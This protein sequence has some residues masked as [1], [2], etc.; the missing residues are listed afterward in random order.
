MLSLTMILNSCD[1]RQECPDSGIMTCHGACMCGCNCMHDGSK[2]GNVPDSTVFH[3][4]QEHD[5]D[6]NESVAAVIP[7]SSNTQQAI[8]SHAACTD[9]P[10]FIL[11]ADTPAVPEDTLYDLSISD[12]MEYAN[13]V[14]DTTENSLVSTDSVSF[15]SHQEQSGGIPPVAKKTQVAFHTNMLYDSFFIP[16]FGLDIDLGK[17]WTAGIDWHYAWWSNGLFNWRQTY[18]G[19]I[20]VDRHLSKGTDNPFDGHRLGLYGQLLTYDFELGFDGQI[21]ARPNYA[22]GLEYGY[23]LPLGSS[24]HLDL[25]IGLG[26]L[27]GEYMK[28]IPMWNEYPEEWHYVWQST[29]KTSYFGVTKAEINLVWHIQQKEDRK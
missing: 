14:S 6:C 27:W 20:H 21:A 12:G 23:S 9:E 29:H 10:L 1:E 25:A 22:I 18:G 3:V 24:L 28:Y 8:S 5:T 26:Y 11:P 19:D 4:I 16:N 13:M 17:R 15:I 2:S 7:V